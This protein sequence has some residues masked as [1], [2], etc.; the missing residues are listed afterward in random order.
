[1]CGIAGIVVREPGRLPTCGKLA[2]VGRSLAHRGPDGSGIFR[3]N[4]VALVHTR[5]SIIDVEGGSQPMTSADG[6]VAVVFNGEIWNYRSLRD[7]LS[8]AGHAFR[9]SSDTEVLVHG[10]EQWGTSLVDRLHGMFAFAI[11]N[12]SEQR[13]FLARDRIGKKPLYLC[14]TDEGV[15]FGSDVR[16]LLLLAGMPVTPNITAV[17]E[18]LFQRYV[19]GPRTLFRGVEKALPGQAFLTDGINTQRWEYWTLPNSEEKSLQPSTLRGLLRE[20]VRER[21]MSDVPLGVLLSGGIDSTAIVGLMHEAG[22]RNVASFTI[23]FEDRVYDERTLARITAQKYGTDHHEL[24][25]GTDDFVAALPR[26]TWYRDEP[27]AEPTEIPLLLLA[28]FAAQHVK[29]VLSGDG[30]DEL[31]GG[32]PK[33]RIERLL[34]AGLPHELL[35]SAGRIASKRRSHRRLARAIETIAI[36]DELLRWASWFRSWSA[37]ELAKLLVPDLRELARPEVLTA[38]LHE[39][40]SQHAGLNPG[41]RMLVGDQLTYLPDNM[42]LRSDKVL[43][44]ASLEGRMPLLNRAIVERVHATP[45]RQR[46]GLRNGKVLLRQAVRD[47]LPDE[48]ALQPKHGF[49]F[50]MSHL[51][52]NPIVDYFLRSDRLAERRLFEP[53]AVR[54]LL[55]NRHA[56]GADLKIFT[57]LSL[58][59]WLRANV[60]QLTLEPPMTF[61]ELD[62]DMPA[63]ALAAS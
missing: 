46:V 52:S 43:M 12:A 54:T 3:Q 50:P 27:M 19:A 22:V 9:T 33:Y 2:E 42:L 30:G 5:L 37:E 34:R 1:M 63:L 15:A 4:P 51:V 25:I 28:E 11:W 58:E 14:E 49:Q 23:G 41:R 53:A 20:S 61:D 6:S 57:L 8:A 44:A 29:V 40:L 36:Q 39:R 13:L 7:E 18:F 56:P 48:I 45:L 16:A 62:S 35:V 38:P 21:L 10:F 32:Y 59:L 24:A 26:L 60:D 47:L 31:F 17:P 55:D